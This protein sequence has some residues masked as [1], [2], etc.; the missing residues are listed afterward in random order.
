VTAA[1]TDDFDFDWRPAGLTLHVRKTGARV[2][3]DRGTIRDVLIGLAYYGPVRI[4]AAVTGLFRPGPR[5]W[6]A[7]DRPRP[8]YLVWGAA[9]WGGMRFVGRPEDADAAFYFEDVTVGRPPATPG[10]RAINFD[11]TDVSK[12]KVAEVFEQVFGYP[13]SVDPEAWTGSAVEKGEKNG[14]HDGR[15]VAC[16]SPRQP[17]RVYQRVI[18]TADGGLVYDYRTPFVGGKPVLVFI[19][20]RPVDERFANFNTRSVLT[21]PEA[22][23]SPDEIERLSAFA[24]AMHLDWGGM[25]V[26]RDRATGRLYVV[27]VNKTDMLVISLPWIDKLRA[28]RR[29]SRALRALVLET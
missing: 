8:W 2:P 14:A 6:F 24:R 13:L 18:D 26:L 21:T 22:L 28:I 9:A 7:P 11:C 29:L 25:D 17:G 27:D 12:T 5:I 20:S 1:W 16:P 10:L 4:K 19:K 15:L 23:Y 3:V